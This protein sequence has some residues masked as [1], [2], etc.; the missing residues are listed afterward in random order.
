[1]LD[2]DGQVLAWNDDAPDK[3]AALITH[4]ADSYLRYK[5][6]AT[7]TYYVQISDAQRHGGEEYAYRLRLS[8]P[9]PDFGVRETPSSL[10]IPAGRSQAVTVYAFRKDGFAGDITVAPAEAEAGFTLSGA[11]IPADKDQVTMTIT[12][13]AEAPGGPVELRLQGTAQIG[14]A[15]VTRPVVPADVMEQAF[16]YYHLVPAQELLVEVTGR[17]RLAT[18]FQL[19]GVFPLHLPAGGTAQVQVVTNAG[20]LVRQQ[21]QFALTNPPAGISLG[22][23]TALA[24]GWTLTVKAAGPAEA[25]AVKVGYADNLLVEAFAEVPVKGKDG[26]VTGQTRRVTI[27]VLPAIPVQIVQQ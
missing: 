4:H 22:P 21:V 15:Q 10:S 26:K 16:A 27:G 3:E 2:A 19:G 6:A 14:G 13:P 9:R 5:L 18:T 17:G 7:G 23:V 11:R 8:L 24:S 25:Q 12:A 1:M 20:P